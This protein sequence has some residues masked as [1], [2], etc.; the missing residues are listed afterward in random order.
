MPYELQYSTTTLCFRAV[1]GKSCTKLSPQTDLS[2]LRDEEYSK[3]GFLKQLE[4][5]K[6]RIEQ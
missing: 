1:S 4:Q 6:L 3:D 2:P 5:L